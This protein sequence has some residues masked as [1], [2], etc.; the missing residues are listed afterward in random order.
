MR[1][2]IRRGLLA[3]A[4]LALGVPIAHASPITLPSGLNPGDTYY[5]AFVTKG[6]TAATSSNIADYDAF[7]TAQANLDP[8]LQALLTTWK[9]IGSTSSVSA[10]THLGSI[11]S[12]IYNLGDQLVASGSLD[13]F[14]GAITNPIQYDQHGNFNP[15]LVFT[16][17]TSSGSSS[18]GHS[19]GVQAVTIGLSTD[20]NEW[21]DAFATVSDNSPFG[22][23][24]LSGPLVVPGA[25]AVPEPGTI[26]LLLGPALLLWRQRWR[27]RLATRT[28]PSDPAVH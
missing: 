15:S 14:D 27:R 11:T 5:L 9:V 10:V 8:D 2:T 12:P 26:S 18:P 25:T 3:F 20:G 17:S 23:Y 22:V 7:V 6:T 4:A 21:I 24:G 19:L 28:T 16:G 1:R 13:L